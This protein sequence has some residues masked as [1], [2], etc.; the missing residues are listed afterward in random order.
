MLDMTGLVSQTRLGPSAEGP[1]RL[2]VVNC[3]QK[4][5]KTE[6]LEVFSSMPFDNGGGGARVLWPEASIGT[7]GG[8]F[9][10]PPQC[11]KNIPQMNFD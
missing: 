3:R 4:F 10:V 8:D 2:S 1:A 7:I 9:D 6:E 11:C 5:F